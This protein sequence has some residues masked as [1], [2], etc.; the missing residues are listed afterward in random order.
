MKDELDSFLGRLINISIRSIKNANV[1]ANDR[2]SIL[3]LL[4]WS[5]IIEYA[6]AIL[7]LLRTEK[8]QPIF[9]L[10]RSMI[11]AYVDIRNLISIPG[12]DKSLELENAQMREKQ[13]N[14]KKRNENHDLIKIFFPSDEKAEQE[15]YEIKKL[16]EEAS[17]TNIKTYK[18]LEKFQNAQMEAEYYTIYIRLSH[19]S[20]ANLMNLLTKKLNIREESTKINVFSE[21]DDLALSPLIDTAA[22]ILASTIE[23]T[24]KFKTGLLRTSLKRLDKIVKASRAKI[25]IIT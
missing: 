2:L 14:Y 25:E 3:I 9:S 17:L 19:E 12:Y 15:K 21:I 13:L 5:F 8:E 24:S 1:Q 10:L 4:K 11:E 6:I 23:R 7:T 18:L 22:G 16:K 20:H